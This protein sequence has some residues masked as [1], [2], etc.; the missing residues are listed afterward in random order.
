MNYIPLYSMETPPQHNGNNGLLLQKFCDYWT[1]NFYQF[2]KTRWVK[3]ASS[4]F[5]G[6]RQQLIDYNKRIE[7]L[8]KINDGQQLLAKTN[9]RFIPGMGNSHPLENGLTWHHTLGVPYLPGSSVKGIVHA[10]AKTWEKADAKDINAICGTNEHVGDIIFLDALPL[11]PIKLEPDIM[12]PHYGNY[13]AN[14]TNQPPRDWDNPIPIP[15]LTVAS[16]Q[17]FVFSLLPRKKTCD[18]KHLEMA[19]N[20]LAQALQIIGAGAKTAVGYGLFQCE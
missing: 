8:T 19:K 3:H 14:P 16:G 13:Y 17:H 4:Q 9:S 5:V 20:W 1:N 12:T 10:W 15:F 6:D 2:E 11:A 7:R 18:P